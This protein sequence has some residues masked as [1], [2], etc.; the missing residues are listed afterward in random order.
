M[1]IEDTNGSKSLLIEVKCKVFSYITN[2]K[3]V[4]KYLFGILI[5]YKE[6]QYSDPVKNETINFVHESCLDIIIEHDIMEC[7]NESTTN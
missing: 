1:Y 4:P 3:K 6:E 5:G 2:T 7:E